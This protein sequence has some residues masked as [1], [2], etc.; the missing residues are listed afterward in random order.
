MCFPI[1]TQQLDFIAA[2]LSYVQRKMPNIP[3]ENIPEGAEV[4]FSQPMNLQTQREKV[5]TSRFMAAAAAAA[6]S[7]Q[8]CPTLCDPYTG[9]GRLQVAYSTLQS[10]GVQMNRQSSG[11]DAEPS[12]ALG[13]GKEVA[14]QVQLL[15]FAE[16]MSLL[17][18]SLNQRQSCIG[19]ILGI[20]LPFLLVDT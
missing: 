8:S 10:S 6:K 14:D 11:S 3:K 12:S 1:V 5:T 20:V 17:T 16:E 4:V 19:H 13:T 9:E 18:A 15:T 2:P 7:L